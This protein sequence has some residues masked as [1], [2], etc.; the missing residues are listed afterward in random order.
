MAQYEKT[1]KNCLRPKLAIPNKYLK[2][3]EIRDR[4]TSKFIEKPHGKLTQQTIRPLQGNGMAAISK[5]YHLT[6]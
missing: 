1:I 4:A 5:N 6:D 2:K 3:I